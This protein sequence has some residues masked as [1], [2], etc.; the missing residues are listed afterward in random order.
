MVSSS[1]GISAGGVADMQNE[2]DLPPPIRRLVVQN[3][4]QELEI[5]LLF[6]AGLIGGVLNTLAGGGSFVTFPA[7]LLAGVPPVAANA[8][9][10]FASLPGYL[11][12]AFG[13]RSDIAK[14]RQKL[15]GFS[16]MAI[17]GGWVGAEL[18][19]RQ[20]DAGFEQVVPWL[21]LLAVLLFIFGGRINAMLMA[22]PSLRG[23]LSTLVPALILFVVCVYG[24]FFNAGLGILLL[25]V[26][27]LSGLTDLHAMNGLKLWISSLVAL[28]AIARFG[29]SDAIA[30]VAG[31]AAFAGTTIGGYTAARLA[32]HV[33]THLLRLGIIVYGTVLTAVFFFK[34][35]VTG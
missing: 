16:A 15:I 8:T 33:P 28:V 35:Y 9:N 6:I 19:L 12:G 26:L 10:T 30:W 22:K 17:I 25:A 23:R 3:R 5:L 24:G 32:R 34:A 18:L 4:G 2:L 13:F 27:A 1:V 31:L 20:S 11:S 21:M 29:I 7:L 14:H